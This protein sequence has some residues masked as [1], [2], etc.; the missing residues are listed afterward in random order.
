VTVNIPLAMFRIHDQQKTASLEHYIAEAET[1]LAKHSRPFGI[2]TLLIRFA[3]RIYSRLQLDT[4]WF[5]AR[6]DS[7]EY[8]VREADW[9]YKKKLEW[10]D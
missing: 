5:G 4:N 3:S 6:S 7:V 1:V 2:P 8:R 10:Q 9:V